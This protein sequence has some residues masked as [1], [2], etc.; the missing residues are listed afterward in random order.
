MHAAANGGVHCPTCGQWAQQYHRS[1]N[2]GMVIG[3]ATIYQ[4]GHVDRYVHLP[5][6][7]GRRS[8]EE[9]KLVY[10]GLVEEE[11]TVRPDGGRAG[12]W[13]C[14]GKGRRFLCGIQSVPRYAIVYDGHLLG[15]DGSNVTVH[16]CYRERFDLGVLLARST[17]TV[18]L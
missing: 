3:L 6:A 17:E 9:S 4:H 2:K 7:V 15:H 18:K 16:D 14:T 12:Y 5:T 11:R 13:R 1:I 10:W 8:S